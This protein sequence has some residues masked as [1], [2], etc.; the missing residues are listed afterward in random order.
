METFLDLLGRSVIFQGILVL[1][2]AGAC[3]YLWV[4]GQPVPKELADVLLVVIGYFF[5]SKVQQ[6][7]R[8]L[9]DKISQMK[10]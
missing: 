4:T 8:S 6:E 5:G 7:T 1:S 9:A 10:R 3:E 2:L